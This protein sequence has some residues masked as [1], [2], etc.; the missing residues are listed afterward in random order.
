MN[1]TKLPI[2]I[3]VIGGIILAAA[4]FA[5]QNI[6]D[7]GLK[8]PS[9]QPALGVSPFL[10]SQA[11]RALYIPTVKELQEALCKAG[12]EVEID[13]VIGKETIRQWNQYCWDREAARFM[14]PTGAPKKENK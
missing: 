13:C 7:N 2:Y 10:P 4:F 8:S 3:F 6:M 5:K 12:Y 14:T 11:S 1:D 9:S